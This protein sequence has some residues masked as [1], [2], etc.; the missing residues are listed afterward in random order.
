MGMQWLSLAPARRRLFVAVIVLVVVLA[1]VTVL[2]LRD[3]RQN[4]VVPVS[5][6]AAG[7]VLLVSGYGG[8]TSALEELAAALEAQ[9][10]QAVIVPAVGDGTGDLREQAEAL[11]QAARDVMQRTGAPSVDVVAYSAGGVVTR[12]W[13]KDLGGG[14]LVR[15]VVTLGS[16]HHGADVARLA[17]VFAPSECPEAC[18]QLATNS[19]L[20]RDL[21]AGDES[22]A[23]PMWVSL[24]SSTDELV[25]PVEGSSL[26]GAINA[27]V[28]SLCG[29]QAIAHGEIPLSAHIQN[30]TLAALTERPLIAVTA[31]D[32]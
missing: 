32:C 18:Q 9:G 21:N 3:G 29:N 14:S 23:G 13:V 11:D 15:R 7:P 12:I 1:A 31:A 4:G 20:L 10:K 24:W 22:P 16:P 26:D 17:V 30:L 27:S 25:V 8:S 2:W 5:Q 19:E 28:Q 6:I